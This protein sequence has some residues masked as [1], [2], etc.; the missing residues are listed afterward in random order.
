MTKMFDLFMRTARSNIQWATAGD[1]AMRKH[2]TYSR[3]DAEEDRGFLAE[4]RVFDLRG[5]TAD[6][7]LAAAWDAYGAVEAPILIS[8]EW[9]RLG[10]SGEID[11]PFLSPPMVGV[12]GWYQ[13]DEVNA[14]IVRPDS[15]S[16]D[17]VIL[18]GK[19]QATVVT[20]V[21]WDGRDQFMLL[22]GGFVQAAQDGG[23]F[24]GWE[25]FPSDPAD[26]ATATAMGSHRWQEK[27]SEDYLGEGNPPDKVAA[28]AMVEALAAL[29]VNTIAQC[30]SAVVASSGVSKERAR[31]LRKKGRIVP[32]GRSWIDLPGLRYERGTF[33]AERAGG[34][35]WHRVRGHWRS[36]RS[37]RFTRK[38][39][40]KVWVQPH[41]RGSAGNGVSQVPYR[42]VI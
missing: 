35:A 10:F 25:V 32:R 40:Q 29:I 4:H 13:L 8:P 42:S 36:L 30:D 16:T 28:A 39:G 37:E 5:P 17:P 14:L 3:E 2:Y 19:V 6:A 9:D 27:L 41:A 22:E 38:Q 18:D 26:R 1:L 24:V 21:G 31:S 11:P 20:Q 34:V 7:V 33:T 23:W 15:A 12:Y